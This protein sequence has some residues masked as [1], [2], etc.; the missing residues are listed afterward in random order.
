MRLCAG[1]NG[2]G[3]AGSHLRNVLS[4]EPSAWDRLLDKLN[5]QNDAHALR[6]LR[7]GGAEGVKLREWVERNMYQRFIPL[8]V[9]EA[10]EVKNTV[11]G[12]FLVV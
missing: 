11:D 10:A 6:L 5:I 4:H 8:K 9:L 1:W 12:R 3:Y 7:E 2:N